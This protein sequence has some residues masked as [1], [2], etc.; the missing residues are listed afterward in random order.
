MFLLCSEKHELVW[1]KKLLSRNMWTALV[2]KMLWL[3]ML[4]GK[5]ETLK[6]VKMALAQWDYSWHH[7]KING[8]SLDNLDCGPISDHEHHPPCFN[9]LQLRILKFPLI[10]QGHPT[11]AFSLGELF[12]LRQG[13]N[14]GSLCLMKVHLRLV[15]FSCLYKKLSWQGGSL[16]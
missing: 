16:K 6:A 13:E 15:S 1:I 12:F 7:I 3:L 10:L 14:H 9:W 8:M 2:Q 5:P 4:A 11:L